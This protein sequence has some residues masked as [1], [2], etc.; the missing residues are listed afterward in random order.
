MQDRDVDAHERI[1]ETAF[2]PSLLPLFYPKTNGVLTPSDRQHGRTNTLKDLHS[3][4]WLRSFVVID[5]S[6]PPLPADLA[7]LSASD[8][9]TSQSEGRVIG[10]A[11]WK[12]YPSPR[13]AEDFAAEKEYNLAGGYPPTANRA[14]MDAFFSA[15]D[16][17]KAR[18]LGN[19][20]YVLLHLLATDPEYHGRGAGAMHLAWGTEEADRLGLDAYLESSAAGRRLYEKFGFKE[21]EMLGFDSRKWGSEE[22]ID[23]AVMLRPK[24]EEKGV[25]GAGEGSGQE[26]KTGAGK[27]PNGTV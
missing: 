5:P 10:T 16:E 21:V 25:S 8:A 18:I 2:Q 17:A 13:T 1:F 9:A 23:H 6:T 26:V 19:R 24:R 11:V 20:A 12:I 22:R 15:I 7:N 4:P 3:H 27:M 14:A